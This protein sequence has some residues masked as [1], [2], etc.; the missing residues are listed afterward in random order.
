MTLQNVAEKLYFRKHTEVET[1][2]HT[3]EDARK[4]L[5][6]VKLKNV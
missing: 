6:T 2:Y 4:K 1:L 5:E 3:V